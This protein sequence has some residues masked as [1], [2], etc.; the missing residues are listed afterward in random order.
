[1]ATFQSVSWPFY[2][3]W[4]LCLE[5][6]PL[7]SKTFQTFGFTPGYFLVSSSLP[8]PLIIVCSRIMF[9]FSSY[10]PPLGYISIVLMTP[11]S[12][13][14][15]QNVSRKTIQQCGCCSNTLNATCWSRTSLVSCPCKA[16]P[17][18]FPVSGNSGCYPHSFFKP[19]KQEL[20]LISHL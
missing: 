8:I 11:R 18:E 6:F 5:T 1:M 19:E 16:F 14:E 15:L 4:L 17:L 3:I 13:L 12:G 20:A 10:S 2:T 9:L 7:T